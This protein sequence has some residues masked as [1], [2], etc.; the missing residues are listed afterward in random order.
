MMKR[1]HEKTNLKT[2][3]PVVSKRP[4]GN[5][6]K[7]YE[8]VTNSLVVAI[9]YG[10]VKQ[11]KNTMEKEKTKFTKQLI[12]I[13][14]LL[15]EL[16]WE[17]HADDEEMKMLHKRK[18]DYLK[19]LILLLGDETIVDCL[20]QIDVEDLRNYGEYFEKL[21]AEPTLPQK[22]PQK[23]IVRF[24]NITKNIGNALQTPFQKNNTIKKYFCPTF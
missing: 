22:L 20:E 18:N 3:E 21:A 19:I 1:K 23:L 6:K 15:C 24:T 12:D 13:F 16:I 14:G 8:V 2:C 4:C 7:S 9:Y 17:I 5:K 10:H 11:V